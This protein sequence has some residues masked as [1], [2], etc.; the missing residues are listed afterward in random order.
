[1]MSLCKVILASLWISDTHVCTFLATHILLNVRTIVTIL[2]YV[3]E[4]G[5]VYFTCRSL[6]AGELTATAVHVTNGLTI[7]PLQLNLESLE[8]IHMLVAEFKQSKS[9]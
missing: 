1:M 7:I 5:K 6:E 4:G 3:F 8:S 2:L 9:E